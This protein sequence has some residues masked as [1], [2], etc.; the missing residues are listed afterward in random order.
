LAQGEVESTAD[1]VQT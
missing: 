1:E